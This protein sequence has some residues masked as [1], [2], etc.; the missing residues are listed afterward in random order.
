[1]FADPTA[2]RRLLDVAELDSKLLHL[3]HQA[4]HLPEN[5]KLSQL[6]VTRLELSEQITAT[7][8]RQDDAQ[9]LLDRA[10]ADLAPVKARLVRDEKRVDDGLVI[11]QRAMASLEAEIEHLKGRIDDLEE[12][13]L[14]AMQQVED[15]GHGHEELVGRRTEIENQMRTLLSQREDTR[16][17]LTRQN[18]E[19]TRRRSSAAGGLPEDLLADYE[20]IHARSGSTGAAEMR[21][22]RCGGCGL[23]IDVAELRRFAAA[24]ATEVLHCEEC[25]RILVRT[26]KSGLA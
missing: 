15:E 12:A 13:E 3:R 23:E 9:R 25:G 10:E 16:A 7:K 19:L 2:Q 21:A 8:T 22:R 24:P 18:E 11:E 5:E 17:K 20:R 14:E 1:M 6:Q 26:E 4:G